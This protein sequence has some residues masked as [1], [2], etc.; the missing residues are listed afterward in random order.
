MTGASARDIDVSFPDGADNKN[1]PKR[2]AIKSASNLVVFFVE[3]QRKRF[4][5]GIVDWNVGENGA[6]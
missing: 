5:H 4:A 2:V 6:V 1:P 3:L